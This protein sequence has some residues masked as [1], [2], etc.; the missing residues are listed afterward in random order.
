MRMKTERKHHERQA[1]G[2]V[3]ESALT[4]L[5]LALTP[6]S[7]PESTGQRVKDELAARLRAERLP[8][9]LVTIRAQDDGWVALAPLIEIKRLMSEGAV[10]SFLLRLQPGARL[11]AH[12]HFDAE[13]CLVLSGEGR[14]G[15]TV[16]RSGDYQFAP[17]GTRHE[18]S[19]TQCG[20]V[21]YVR[22][23]CPA[24]DCVR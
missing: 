9:K 13:E 21:L 15:G 6:A 23:N 4:P 1:D 19:T 7:V 2:S 11:P 8:G 17:A 12:E 18:I 14:V 20:V 24:L 16:L 22:G 3:P 5:L 10:H